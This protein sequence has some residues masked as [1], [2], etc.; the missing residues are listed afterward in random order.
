MNIERRLTRLEAQNRR[1]RMLAAGAFLL[2]ALPWALGRR[3]GVEDS[4]EAK[5]FALVNDTGSPVGEWTYD[6]EKQTAELRMQ[7]K[8]RSPSIVL[9]AKPYETSA[10][11]IG[12]TVTIERGGKTVFVAPPRMTVVPVG[13]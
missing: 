9:T 4:V 13:D 3:E 1:L 2:A 10:K 6:D 12:G 11:L 8:E 7:L 5:R